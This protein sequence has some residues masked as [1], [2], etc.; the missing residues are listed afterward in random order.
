MA[1]ND[2]LGIQ[3]GFFSRALKGDPFPLALIGVDGREEISRL[4]EIDL[5]LLRSSEPL[6]ESQLEALVRDPCVIA[7]GVKKTD[8]VHGL[9]SAIEHVA[10]GD[11]RGTYYRAKMRPYVSLLGLGRRSAIYQN[12][13]VPEMVSAI[14]T[15]YGLAENKDF[16]IRVADAAKS[17]RHEYVVQYKESDWHFIERWLEWE[18]FFYF[19]RHGADGVRLVIADANDGAEPLPDPNNVSYRERNNLGVGDGGE[20]VWTFRARHERVPSSVTLVDY[21]EERPLDMFLSSHDVD[22]DAGFGHVVHYAE[23][24]DD[25]AVGAAWAKIRSEELYARRSVV[26]GQTDCAR[27]RAGHT[28]ALEDHPFPPYDRRYLV[29]AVEHHAGV[30]ARRGADDF[31]ELG[32]P[33]A[34]RARF[35]AIPLDVPFRPERR[36]RWPR[37][38]GLISAH[39]EADTNGDFAQIDGQ[40]RY[41]VKFTW[42]LDV[43]KG[44]PSSRWIRM[45]QSY[46]GAGYG[47]HM[48]QHKGTEVLIAHIDGD[49]DRPLIVGAVPNPA[50]P[51][52]VVDRNATQSVLQTAS[53]IRVELEDRA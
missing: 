4:F 28:F 3:L 34:Y 19:F 5:L 27:M 38:H 6:E 29:T 25:K 51:S 16:E 53:G 23:H 49:P 37:I 48:P 50:T 41:K 47:Q 43:H 35:E 18:G 8:I 20:T 52:P 7:L 33:R 17:P 15:A 24:F 39:V 13:T 22:R 30:E 40:G 21:N 32:A 1:E 44:L 31:A 46:A 45:A 42:D 12:V 11:G 2:K 9:L 36:T 26:S 10:G 14:L